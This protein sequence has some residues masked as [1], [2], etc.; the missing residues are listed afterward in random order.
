MASF[1][2]RCGTQNSSDSQFCIQCGESLA[3]LP[4]VSQPGVTTST[5]YGGFWIRFLAFI[6][7]WVLVQLVV[8]PIS[9]AVGMVVGVAGMATHSSSIGMQV[10]SSG[11]GAL[12]GLAGTWL[13]NA[14]MESSKHQATLGK[15]IFGMKVTDMQGQ[16]LSFS[17][18]SGRHFA[19]ILSGLILCIGF[20]MIGFSEKKQGLHDMI[21][22][23]VVR[24]P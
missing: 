20:I 16:R 22:G 13:Y 7:D 2:S 14:M 19:K 4:V 11:I 9:F 21:A 3:P 6:I 1:C 10:F 12:I 18:A 5:R 8:V 15:M 24:L 23:T 17:L